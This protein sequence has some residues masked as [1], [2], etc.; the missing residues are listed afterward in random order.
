MAYPEILGAVKNKIG[1][2]DN[3]KGL[4][5]NHYSDTKTTENQRRISHKKEN[6][7]LTSLMTID[8]KVLKKMLAN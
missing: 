8:A 4:R 7:R 5:D 3:H 2:M 6:S 1:C